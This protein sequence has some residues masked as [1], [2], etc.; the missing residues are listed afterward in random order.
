MNAA[1]GSRYYESPMVMG[2]RIA[3]WCQIKQEDPVELR[4]ILLDAYNDES[5]RGTL[6]YPVYHNRI[7]P[8]AVSSMIVNSYNW[9][10][11][12]MVLGREDFENY[13]NIY[14]QTVRL[15]PE[16]MRERQYDLG[17]RILKACDN[18]RGINTL[19]KMM[20]R[21]RPSIRLHASP[22]AKS[23]VQV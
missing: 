7:H 10:A 6:I 2:I 15:D 20:Y 1:L 21:A 23:F 14:S 22:T 8:D 12:M 19:E 18:E 3:E 11:E 16:K 17:E 4:E 13:I 5:L 9:A